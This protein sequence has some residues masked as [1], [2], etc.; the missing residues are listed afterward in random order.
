MI[1]DFCFVKK[2]KKMFEQQQMSHIRST[3][4]DDLK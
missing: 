3:G 1:N 2:I 4:V